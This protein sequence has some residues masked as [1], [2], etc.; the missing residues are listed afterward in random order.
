M[1][2]RVFQRAQKTTE[3]HS[4]ETAS[5]SMPD[6]SQRDRM[7]M[8]QLAVRQTRL[9]RIALVHPSPLAHPIQIYARDHQAIFANR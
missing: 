8:V 9:L 2:E 5:I 1:D 7:N 4:T 6:A 3:A